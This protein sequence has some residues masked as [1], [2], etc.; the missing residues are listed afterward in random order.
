MSA[1]AALAGQQVR[2]V[3]CGQAVLLPPL[4]PNLANLDDAFAE[5]AVEPGAV[6]PAVPAASSRRTSWRDYLYWVLLVALVPLVVAV[7]RG[8]KVDFWKRL[9]HTVAEHPELGPPA[10][11]I[12]DSEDGKLDDLLALLPGKKVDDDAWLPRDSGQHWLYAAAVS[13]VTFVILCYFFAPRPARPRSLIVFGVF[14]GTISVLSLF[15]LHEIGSAAQSRYMTTEQPVYS[16]EDAKEEAAQRNFVWTLINNTLG[17]GLLE[18]LCKALPLFWLR[19][20]LAR[21]WRRACVWGL[22]TGF[23]FGVSEAIGYAGELYNGIHSFDMYLV[24]FLSCVSLHAIWSASVAM[25]LNRRHASVTT[26]IET[27][28]H[29]QKPFLE[30]IGPLIS[31]LAIAAC[32]HGMYDTFLDY[33]QGGFALLVAVISFAWLAW[34]IETRREEE[35]TACEK[36][37]PPLIVVSA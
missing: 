4:E 5:A 22:A 17:V 21:S 35:H 6:P 31:V 11:R 13:A 10:Q 1:D 9:N 8:G 33:E 37:D 12:L 20:I 36:Q 14:G 27:V 34:Q 23:G 3:L 24:R 2:C 19:H 29:G 16:S 7:F 25:T 26:D 32:L 18:E 28:F 30:F 15:A